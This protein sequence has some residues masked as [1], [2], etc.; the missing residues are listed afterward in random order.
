MPQ[1]VILSWLA[2]RPGRVRYMPFLCASFCRVLCFR[3]SEAR[4]A[5]PS[6]VCMFSSELGIAPH[7]QIFTLLIRNRQTSITIS[8]THD[9]NH[10]SIS[11]YVPE[12]ILNTLRVSTSRLAPATTSHHYP[13]T[14]PLTRRRRS[15]HRHSS[16]R[17]RRSMRRCRRA[18]RRASQEE[19]PSTEAPETA[20][21]APPIAPP[22]LDAPPDASPAA[23]PQTPSTATRHPASG[24]RPDRS[25]HD[26]VGMTRSRWR[27]RRWRRWATA[28]RR[29]V[30]P[31]RLVLAVLF[32]VLV[33]V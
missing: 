21:N 33:L 27:R 22:P 12:W 5:Q 3:R 25:D 13:D 20:P 29:L 1:H 11:H 2:W 32:L 28:V 31:R 10:Y 30:G 16:M 17:R 26:Q 23:Q 14:A 9:R 18:A 8:I 6:R 24:R 7:P 4:V 15:M 19:P